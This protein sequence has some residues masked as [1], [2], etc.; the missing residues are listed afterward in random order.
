MK[1]LKIITLIAAC[2][3]LSLAAAAQTN[4]VTVT[5]TVVVTVTVT[6]FVTVTNVVAVPPTPPAGGPVAA[7]TVDGTPAVPPAEPKY[8]WNSSLTAGLTMA[9]GNSHSLLYSGSLESAKKTPDNEYSLGAAGAF[10]SSDG[11]DSV[12]NYGGNAQWN[13]LFTERFYSYLRA[14]AKRDI[15]AD[16]DYRFNLGPGAG[17]YLI[18][19]TNTSLAVEA[20]AGYDYEHLGSEYNSFMMVRLAEKFE[21]KFSDRARIWQKVEFIP[22]VDE[23]DNYLVNFE[24]GAEAALTKVFSLKTTLQDNYQRQAAAGRLKNDVLIISGISYKF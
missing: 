24:V 7:A 17:Y 5:N 21:R 2:T 20:G 16:L 15:I 3:S 8:P 22:Q 1:L 9:R 18:K 23:L 6:N 19:E 11:T 13:H 4:Y 14:E 10:G 12:N